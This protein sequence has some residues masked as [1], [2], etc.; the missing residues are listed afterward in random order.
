M[1][2]K[3]L[4]ISS[5]NQ[6]TLNREV[7][8]ALGVE[9]GSKV[10]F[11]EAPNGILI[12]KLESLDVCPVC[13]GEVI[14]LNGDAQK[15][16]I[17]NGDGLFKELSIELIIGKLVNILI[18]NNISID[19]EKD[20]DLQYIINSKSSDEVVSYYI[21]K[22]Q[23]YIIK[24]SLEALRD[25]GT[26]IDNNLKD[27][28]LKLFDNTTYLN[29]MLNIIS[30]IQLDTIKDILKKE[31]S[32]SKEQYDEFVAVFDDKHQDEVSKFLLPFL[33]L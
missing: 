26:L 13:K 7:R 9:A 20:N 11:E 16:L 5:K 22:C 6:I 15:C 1:K 4:T 33:T 2:F 18:S 3:H 30:N 14:N 27:K 31:S 32:I 28:C 8:E 23:I 21:N 29:T 19:I 17:C 24:R 12:K 10:Y 25:K